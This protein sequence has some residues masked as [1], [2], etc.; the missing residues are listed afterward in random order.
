MTSDIVPVFFK[1]QMVYIDA[2]EREDDVRSL[3]MCS[4]SKRRNQKDKP[5]VV[6]KMRHHIID[7]LRFPACRIGPRNTFRYTSS[8][9]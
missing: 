2:S 7:P 1:K 4:C 5:F 9:I 3:H 6:A 8:G